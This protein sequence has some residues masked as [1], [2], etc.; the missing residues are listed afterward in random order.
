MY[1][2]YLHIYYKLTNGFF[3]G[4]E[5]LDFLNFNVFHY[6][7]RSFNA[8]YIPSHKSYYSSALAI[9]MLI[10]ISNDVPIDLFNFSSIESFKTIL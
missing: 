4:P 1:I 2:K 10:S 5:L 3:V 9:N 8:Y 7:V 6:R